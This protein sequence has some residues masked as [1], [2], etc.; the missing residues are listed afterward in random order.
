MQFYNQLY[1]EQFNRQPKLDGL[2]FN[3]IC[4]KDATR[5]ARAFE[6]TEVFEIVRALNGDEAPNGFSMAFFYTCWE[7]LKNDIIIL[8]L[9]V[10]SPREV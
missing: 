7:I 3:S 10:S 9:R 8:F 5:L 6:E 2:S 4:A 1:S